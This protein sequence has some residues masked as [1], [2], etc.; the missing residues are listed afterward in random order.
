MEILPCPKLHLWVV[1]RMHSSRMH[2]AYLL[3]IPWG[4]CIH[5]G[6]ASRGGYASGGGGSTSRGWGSASGGGVLHLE[7]LHP[8]GGQTPLHPV[9]RQTGVK[10]LPC[11]KLRLRAVIIY[12]SP[13]K[14]NKNELL[15]LQNCLC[16]SYLC[17][18]FTLTPILRFKHTTYLI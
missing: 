11:P 10:T 4:V 1:T 8:G 16:L 17:D 7:G 3:T 9:K 2:T 14:Y 15:K 12:K 18:S 13:V 5:G 6:S